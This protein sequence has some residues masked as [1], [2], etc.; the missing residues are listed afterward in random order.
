MLNTLTLEKTN[1]PQFVKLP[2]IPEDWK[3]EPRLQEEKLEQ[4]LLKMGFKP[5]SEDLR[6]Q[7]IAAGHYG[8][9][10]D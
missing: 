2:E 10:Q 9:P 8:M 5:L 4:I 1:K 7:L 6:N 3:R